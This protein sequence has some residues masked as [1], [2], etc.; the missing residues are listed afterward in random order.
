MQYARDSRLEEIDADAFE[1]LW[2]MSADKPYP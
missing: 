1:R 2:S